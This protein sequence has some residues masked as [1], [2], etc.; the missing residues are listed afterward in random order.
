MPFRPVPASEYIKFTDTYKD[1]IQNAGGIPVNDA[2]LSYFN[3][4]NRYQVYYGGRGSGKSNFVAQKLIKN[5]LNDSFFRCIYCR[6]HAVDIREGQ[7]ALLK[8]TIAAWGLKKAFHIH[9]T[10]MKIICLANENS[11][12]A[13]GLD[14]ADKT[15]SMDEP[16]CLWLEEPTEIEQEEFLTL[17]SGLRTQKA[18]LQTVLSFN[19]IQE[20]H[21]LRHMFFHPKN[22]HAPIPDKDVSICRT[23]LYDNYFIDRAT[24]LADLLLGAHG[25]TNIVRVNIEGDWGVG[26]NKDPW[27]YSF[28]LDKHSRDLKFL[29]DYPIYLS[30]D[31]NTEPFCCIA[32]QMSGNKGNKE[33]FIHFLREFTIG[34]FQGKINIENMCMQIKTMYPA[35]ILYVT[36]DRNGSNEETGL[37]KTR[38]AI[39]Q[40]LLNVA[41]KQMHI[42]THNLEHADSR[43]LCNAM[44]NNYP[45]IYFDKTNCPNLILDCQ[46]ATVDPYNKNPSHL[47][48]DRG[49]YKM[50]IF[51]AMRYHF[52]TYWNE[53]AVQTY[54]KAPKSNVDHL[55]T[56]HAQR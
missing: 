34:N 49:Q 41:D 31:F 35:S 21:W 11:F 32:S 43:I 53:W 4:R 2:Y 16:S 44:L 46:K 42:N 48:K 5:C 27:L 56:N 25:N 55:R 37:N 50:D 38:Y 24:Y 3:T 33:S 13:R 1:L 17:N 52:Q 7:F 10:T 12:I 15:K 54:F 22:A 28:S 40:G 18:V 36:G 39:I 47:L 14:E 29:P 51:D 8:S 30:F 45:N 20:Q 9:E 26:E 23:T 6:K 19:P